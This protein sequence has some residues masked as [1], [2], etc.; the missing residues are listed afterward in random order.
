MTQETMSVASN[1][2][3]TLLESP[4]PRKYRNR[5]K[6]RR[7]GSLVDEDRDD[8]DDDEEVVAVVSSIAHSSSGDLI[9]LSLSAATDVSESFDLEEA[10]KSLALTQT[11]DKE[12]VIVDSTDKKNGLLMLPI[13]PSSGRVPRTP[14]STPEPPLVIFSDNEQSEVV[15]MSSN[16]YHLPSIK[17][18][19][20]QEEHSHKTELVATLTDVTGLAAAS[21]ESNTVELV[22]RNEQVLDH[23]ILLSDSLAGMSLTNESM[24]DCKT[25]EAQ[26]AVGTTLKCIVKDFASEQMQSLTGTGDVDISI[27]EWG[28]HPPSATSTEFALPAHHLIQEPVE[29]ELSPVENLTQPMPIYD[30]MGSSS[31]SGL[32]YA[33]NSSQPVL[34]TLSTTDN[35]LA[36]FGD[37]MFHKLSQSPCHNKRKGDIRESKLYNNIN[38]ASK[39]CTKSVLKPR[40]AKRKGDASDVKPPPAPASAFTSGNHLKRLI[41]RTKINESQPKAKFEVV[42]ARSEPE[43]TKDSMMHHTA[44]SI[45]RIKAADARKTLLKST[46]AKTS[47]SRKPT[48]TKMTTRL[49]VRG[50]DPVT[51]GQDEKMVIIAQLDPIAAEELYNSQRN[52]KR[53]LNAAD[54]EAASN[55]LYANA[56]EAKA[57]KESKREELQEMYTFAPQ[58]NKYKRR[59]NT[60]ES[61]DI[62]NNHFSHLH[63]HAKKLIEKKR[64]L[65]QQHERDGCTFVPSISRRAKQLTQPNRGSR[66]ENL[67]KDAEEI[68]QK[69]EMKLLEQIKTNEEQCPFR[70]TTA[71]SRAQV[72]TRPLYDSEREKSKR[73]AREQQKIDSELSNCTFKPQVLSAKRL[74]S[75]AENLSTAT[76]DTAA[77]ADPFSRLYQGSIDRTERLL[78]LRQ[79]RD[80]QEKAQAPFQP[81]ISA[82]SRTLK[83]K[84]KEPF[85]DRLYNKDYYMQVD[86]QREQRRLYGEQQFTFKPD[87]I[88]PP[89]E[90]QIKINERASSDKSIFER[91]YDQKDKVKEK[92]EMSEELRLLNELAECTFRPQIGVDAVLSNSEPTPP[93]WERLLSYD[94]SQVIEER[95]KL[96][97]QLEML[98][99]TFKPEV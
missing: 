60:E 38:T 96:K 78:K 69:R 80:E 2:K 52:V 66:Y 6:G 43:L 62:K 29:A 30:L 67:Y 71:I 51:S 33:S 86:A 40:S 39:S 81:K 4:T 34:E 27:S 9:S 61:E 15:P 85:Y 94:K 75:R 77:V 98:E 17:I 84:A 68:K 64:D 91:L 99:C 7:S 20:S 65:Q 1:I 54:A 14:P 3:A 35:S 79:E 36:P 53:R 10:L 70:P 56:M 22:D 25:V 95:E 93:V 23:E 97:E 19:A 63:A 21:K 37:K 89:K 50:V 83:V 45:T 11:A 82:R 47:L 41:S 12:T 74:K 46:A 76:A 57:R 92:I 49:S 26:F 58:V 59:M 31:I 13:H 72:R 28:F 88:A 87:I 73:L 44:K 8:D 42:A 16:V 24:Q 90:I 5:K 48:R 18:E 32:N 55:R